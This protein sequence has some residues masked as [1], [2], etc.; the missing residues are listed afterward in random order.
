MPGRG[1]NIALDDPGASRA[2]SGDWALACGAAINALPREYQGYDRGSEHGF[3]PVGLF[4]VT[5]YKSVCI[6]G[7]VPASRLAGVSFCRVRTSRHIR[8]APEHGSGDRC[9]KAAEVL[10]R[11][12]ALVPSGGDNPI[13]AALRLQGD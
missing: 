5:P 2:G 13:F 10:G 12:A 4:P 1:V 8:S 11:M 6:D 3:L 7:F 9:L